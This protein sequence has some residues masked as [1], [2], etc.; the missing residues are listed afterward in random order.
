MNRAFD[1]NG[2][3]VA[4]SHPVRQLKTVKKTVYIDSADR[5]VVK[6]PNNGE[7]VVY[8]PRVYENVVS[9]RLKG[10]EFPIVDTAGSSAKTY[11]KTTGTTGSLSANNLYFFIEVDGLNKSDE[12]VS[13]AQRSTFVDTVFAKIQIPDNTS[14]IMYSEDNGP[15]NINYYRPAIGK[16]DRFAIRTRLHGQTTSQSIY[17]TQNYALTVELD[18]LENSYDD[19]S[20]IE[21]RV[22]TRA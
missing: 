22:Q 18:I 6:Y 7:F 16:L 9:I 2:V 5:D 10:A 11:D 17:W 19:F 21:T 12:T 1:Y 3:Q 15:T 14:K 8:L 20:S 13:T 4:P